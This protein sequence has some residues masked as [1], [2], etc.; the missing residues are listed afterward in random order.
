[1]IRSLK[2]N[3]TYS[4]Y[5]GLLK[6]RIY[7]KT[8]VCEHLQGHSPLQTLVLILPPPAP[9]IPSGVEHRT[10]DRVLKRTEIRNKTVSSCEICETI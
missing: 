2:S 9:H 10:L 8:A 5:G 3:P 6:C 4:D 1:M 7:P